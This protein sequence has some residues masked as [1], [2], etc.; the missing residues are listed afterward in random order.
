MFIESRLQVLVTSHGI[1]ISGIHLEDQ[2]TEQKFNNIIEFQRC[3]KQAFELNVLTERKH[4]TGIE[5]ECSKKMHNIQYTIYMNS[6]KKTL[7]GSFTASE[8]GLS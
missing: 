3:L 7:K 6:P 8:R 5:L 2:N 4:E 1:K